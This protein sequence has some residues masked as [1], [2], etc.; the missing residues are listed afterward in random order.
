LKILI[1]GF[2]HPKEDKRVLRT[3]RALSEK[4]DVT[5]VYWAKE[6][7]H[8]EKKGRIEYIPA[9]YPQ[10]LGI[11]SRLKFERQV[12]KMLKAIDCDLAYFHH[13]Q[14]LDPFG[15]YRAMKGIPII[16]DIHEY[17]PDD[18]M[19]G[20]SRIPKKARTAVGKVIF[21]YISKHS[22]G[23]VCV[24][25]MPREKSKHTWTYL[26]ENLGNYLIEPLPK[27]KRKKEILLVGVTPRNFDR[28]RFL[29]W[30]LH[31]MGFEITMIGSRKEPDADFIKYEPFIENKELLKRISTAAF[32]FCSFDP[33]DSKGNIRISY[34]YSLPNKFYDSICAGTPVIVEDDFIEMSRNL[35][36]GVG[37]IIPAYR[38]SAAAKKILHYWE[39]HY[40]GLI[41]NIKTYQNQFV[42]NETKKRTFLEFVE[43]V[44]E[45]V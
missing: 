17:V 10:H 11:R 37:L 40:N 35:F 39:N 41:E 2:M 44:A 45:R 5:Y 25:E 4:H 19:A 29:F 7:E 20:V 33:H 14:V 12:T 30:T 6:K 8:R 9:Y 28:E 1:V 22:D 43:E 16:T 13:Y 24:S 32:S 23:L 38:A 21:R 3:V 36:N 31:R 42:F 27:E 15:P 26:F 34:I 18:Y